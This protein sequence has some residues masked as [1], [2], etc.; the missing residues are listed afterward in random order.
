MLAN[1]C[2]ILETSSKFNF[3]A[4]Y[5]NDKTIGLKRCDYLDLLLESL[6]ITLSN[7]VLI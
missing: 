3:E 1:N 6:S 2:K 7:L 5:D 4:N